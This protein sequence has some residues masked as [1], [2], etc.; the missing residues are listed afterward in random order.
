MN[1][2]NVT[3]LDN[4][5]TVV[6]ENLPYVRSFSLGIWFN[7]G[8]KNETASNNGISHFIEHMLFK[9]TKNRTA[10]KIA[11]EIESLGGYLNAFTSKEHTCFYG[12]GLEQHLT[13]TF[14]VLADMILNSTFKEKDIKR[15]AGVILDELYDIED[16]PEE[17]IFDK[18]ENSIY[19]GNSL[20]YP[21]IGT[22]ANIASFTRGDIIDYMTNFYSPDNMYVVAS[23]AVEHERI[24][25]LSNKYFASLQKVKTKKR[26]KLKLQSASNQFINKEVQQTHVILGRPTIGLNHPKRIAVSLLSNIL[27]EGSSSRLFQALRERNGITYQ[28]NSFLNSFFDVSS[29]GIYFSTNAKFVLKAVGI[30]EK[31]LNKLRAKPVSKNELKRTKEFIKGNVIMS[32]ESTTNRMVRMAQSMIYHNRIKSV[33]ETIKEIDLLNTEEIHS[34]AKDILNPKKF[35]KVIISPDKKIMDIAA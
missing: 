13:K 8:S 14:D 34:L 33:E 10:R 20:H 5:L 2:F 6:T 3:K 12:R 18:F 1:G 30:I 28:I 27:G 9:G 7:T 31:E 16:S 35:T 21:I 29:F 32:L 15:E 4:G 11:D 22:A 23:G 17:L 25:N 26:K 24:V 19:K